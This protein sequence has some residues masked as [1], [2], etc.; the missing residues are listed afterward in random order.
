MVYR[1]K[2]FPTLTFSLI[3]L[4]SICFLLSI[5]VLSTHSNWSW[6]REGVCSHEIKKFCFIPAFAFKRP[7]SFLTSAF[8]H[9]D[10][11]HLFFNMFSLFLFGTYLESRIG[12][13]KFFTIYLL[14]A[15]FGSLAYWLV[16]PTSTTPAL[17]ASAAIFGIIGCLAILHPGLLVWIGF[18]VPLIL[19]AM[20]WGII[21][22]VGIFV[23]SHIAHHAHLGGLAFGILAGILLRRKKRRIRVYYYYY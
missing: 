7:W 12:K 22:F 23:P 4:N 17:G 19:A 3:F 9:A 1:S 6:E 18:P 16:S 14:S 2:R 15:F 21:S 20:I 13:S 10:F 11:S 5:L 8:L